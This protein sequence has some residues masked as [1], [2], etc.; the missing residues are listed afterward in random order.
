MREIKS[1][2][3]NSEIDLSQM[4][5]VR[6]WMMV[7]MAP[8]FCGF[9]VAMGLFIPLASGTSSEPALI[10]ILPW[11]PISFLFTAMP[12]SLLIKKTRQLQYELDEVRAE[13]S[14]ARN[15]QAEAP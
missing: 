4:N 15:A 5:P 12:L 8:I 13:L 9:V 2:Q 11:I 10:A 14:E 7:W 6:A 3:L 1:A